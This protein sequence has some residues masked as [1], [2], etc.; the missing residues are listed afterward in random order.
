MS[1][2]L[3]HLHIPKTGGSTITKMLE[4][5][6]GDRYHRV[7]NGQAGE[8]WSEQAFNFDDYDVI[9]GH[10]VYAKSDCPYITFLRNPIDRLLSLHY[11]FGHTSA[12]GYRDEIALLSFEQFALSDFP[13]RSL[14]DEL[15]YFVDN[16]MVRRISGM[17]K[18]YRAVG[19]AE[20]GQAL[21]NLEKFPFVGL[22]EYFNDSVR[23]WEKLF[24]WPE[25]EYGRYLYQPDRLQ[26]K[27][28]PNRL[29][30]EITEKQRYDFALYRA[31][32]ERDWL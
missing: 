12:K 31:V 11:Y 22:V 29:I 4:G 26:Q 6:Y 25:L 20:L 13:T 23:R 18:V 27:K 3:L 32:F 17:G 5:Y 30:G 19:E 21:R 1:M 8:F 7:P 14:H 9:S 15:F 24:G 16:D 2:K 28:L 10:F